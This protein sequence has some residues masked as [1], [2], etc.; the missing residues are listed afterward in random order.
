MACAKGLF[1]I[2]FFSVITIAGDESEKQV[3]EQNYDAM[4]SL[5]EQFFA[6]KSYAQALDLYKQVEPQS[7]S[8][9]EQQWVKFRLADAQWRS[10]A[11]TRRSDK[12]ELS[13]A[14]AQLDQLFRQYTRADDYDQTFAEI[15]ESLGDYEWNRRDAHNWHQAWPFYEKALD[16]WAGNPDIDLA[17]TRYLDI[18]W[19][20]SQPEAADVWYYYGYYGNQLPIPIIENVLKIAQT[21]D[22]Q[23]HAH[24]LMAMTLTRQGQPRQQ[25]LVADEF[26][27]AIKAGKDVSWYD[28]ALYRYAERLAQAGIPRQQ[29][30]GQW[31]QQVDYPKALELFRRLIK[32]F[33]EGET[34]YYDQTLQQIKNITQAQL[35]LNVTNVFLPDSE[36]QY[37]LYWRNVKAI[38]LSAAP[39]GFNL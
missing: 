18:V 16:W 6:E 28:D 13:N 8:D 34:R 19:K 35:S 29:A 7:L 38:E 3:P 31:L 9:S 21:P 5:A 32:E 24:Y 36:I 15:C 17:R 27:Q 39:C 12:S 2:G 33:K 26:E 1:L 37:H 22:D 10:L 23:A 30:D 4:K 11:S 20:A 25:L 14:R